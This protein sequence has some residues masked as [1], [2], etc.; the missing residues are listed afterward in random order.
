MTAYQTVLTTIVTTLLIGLAIPAT[1][2]DGDHYQFAVPGEQ[3]GQARSKRHGYEV[4]T[5]LCISL[6][7]QGDF[8]AAARFCEKAVKVAQRNVKRVRTHSR[9]AA[10]K[11][12]HPEGRQLALALNNRGVHAAAA[13]ETESAHAWF[14]RALAQDPR[15]RPAQANVALAGRNLLA[16]NR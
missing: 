6:T 1:A 11:G 16:A 8:R 2:A 12:V 10:L 7:Q 4:A 5:G 3:E 13:G 14:L 15:L 9:P